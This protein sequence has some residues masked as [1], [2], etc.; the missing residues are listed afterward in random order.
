MFVPLLDTLAEAGVDL[1]G[2]VVTADALH[3]QR[4]HAEALHARGVD[5]CFSVKENQCATRRSD[6]SPLQGHC[7]VVFSL[8][9][10][11]TAAW[12]RWA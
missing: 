2:A 9:A 12:G 11:V 6:A 8:V 10:R 4:A 7:V 3:T 5:F 1:A